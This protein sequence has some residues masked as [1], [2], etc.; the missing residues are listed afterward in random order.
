MSLYRK[1][2]CLKTYKIALG[3]SPIG[4]KHQE[5][6]NK[7]P[8]GVYKISLKN[9]HG[10]AGKTLL[11]SYPNDEDRRQARL[12]RRNPGGNVCIH[13]LWPSLRPLGARHIEH[14]WTLGCIAV[15]DNEIE[16]IYKIVKNNTVIEILP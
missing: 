8:E 1:G 16:E 11:I 3:G 9:P 10:T 13:G 5:G 7:T 15:T 12:A 14:D 4:H 2:I 6:D